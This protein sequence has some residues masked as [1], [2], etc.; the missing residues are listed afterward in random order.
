MDIVLEDNME[1][2]SRFLRLATAGAASGSLT[3][4]LQA[5]P[6]AQRPRF[7]VRDRHHIAHSRLAS[8]TNM[9]YMETPATGPTVG[10][11]EGH[12]GTTIATPNAGP[13]SGPTSPP[14]S[15]GDGHRY[16]S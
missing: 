16:A 3:T 13:T 11:T 12:F 14:R 2:Y 10:P 9:C 4:L 5:T 1:D 8:M 7:A 6:F 15:L